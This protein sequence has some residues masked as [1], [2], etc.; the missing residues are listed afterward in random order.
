MKQRTQLGNA[1]RGHLAGY[2]WVAPEGATHL[3]MLV[4]LLE[5]GGIGGTLPETA[6][7]MFTMLVEMLAGLDERI[8]ALDKEIARRAGEDEVV[9]RL[10][11]IPGIGPITATAIAVIAP[12][13]ETFGKGRNFAAWLGWCRNRPR[14]AANRSSVRSPRWESECCGGCS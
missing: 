14:P 13:S 4:D 2:G 12:P 6:R 8:A 7:P 3:A 5:G 10:M 11:T 1:I 9:R